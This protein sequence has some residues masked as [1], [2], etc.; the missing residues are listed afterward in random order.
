MPLWAKVISRAMKMLVASVGEV[1]LVARAGM[2]ISGKGVFAHG[3]G[4]AAI[5]LG[6]FLVLD[7]WL[8]LG[9]C[10]F[11]SFASRCCFLYVLRQRGQLISIGAPS[12]GLTP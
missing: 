2:G 4:E 5:V 9:S 11:M 8:V 1:E 6:F 10:G 12:I 3:F 7:M